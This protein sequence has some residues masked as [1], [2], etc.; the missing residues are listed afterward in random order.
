MQPISSGN[1]LSPFDLVNPSNATQSA[2]KDN[3]QGQSAKLREA[4]GQ[5]EGLVLS[6]LWKSMSES[7]DSPD[8]QS[9]AAH[10]TIQDWGIEI[11]SG[12]VGKAGG[13]G[14][15]KLILQHLEPRPVPSQTGTA[16]GG[17]Q[18]SSAPADKQ[19]K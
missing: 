12:A 18:V 17:S 15:G 7:F 9:D 5:F 10:G 19:S 1:A 4:A 3:A 8:G 13:L 2:S 16:A 6:S 11:M 14:L